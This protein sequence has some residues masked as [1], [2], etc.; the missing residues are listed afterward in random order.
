[1]SELSVVMEDYLAIRRALGFKLDKDARVLASFVG[2]LDE[3]GAST[4]S[5]EAALAW[6]T[7]APRR[8]AQA[9]ARRLT[10]IRG[11]AKHLAGQDGRSEVPPVEV[12]PRRVRRSTPH[13]YSP[14]EIAALMAAARILTPPLRAA[15]MET[16]IGLLAVSGMRSGEAMRLDRNDLEWRQGLLVVRATKFGKSREVPLH[17][18]TLAA[19]RRYERIR[20]QL[21]PQPRGRAFFVSASGARLSSASFHPTFT[22]VVASAGLVRPGRPRPRPHDLRHSFAVATLAELYAA[23]ADVEA[24][25]PVLSTYLGHNDPASTYWYLS[26]APELLALI[27]RRLEEGGQK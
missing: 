14:A 7:A 23:G 17:S 22:K 15:T 12:L 10:V 21:C 24:S 9:A 18:T 6:A 3:I 4:V 13:L 19:L 27:A 5:T 11:F 16:V 26:A 2:Y 20:D 8:S 1:M 25:L